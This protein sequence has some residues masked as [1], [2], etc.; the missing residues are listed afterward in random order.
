M[1]DIL[2][3]E[4]RDVMTYE[5]ANG[6]RAGLSHM[7]PRSRDDLAKRRAM[8]KRWMDSCGGM[9]GRTP[10]FL[11]IMVAAFAAGRQYFGVAGKAFAAD[12]QR[13][14]ALVRDDDLALT[15]SL[16]T[17]DIDK[18]KPIYEQP[19]DVATRV[20]REGDSG[21]HA[22]GGAVRGHLGVTGE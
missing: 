13:Y 7:Q 6:A 18:S 1:L 14:H 8:V 17:P 11:N 20:V 4:L 10:D 2:V 22:S 16:V 12:M 5:I 21:V 3:E 19:R 9:M 15:H